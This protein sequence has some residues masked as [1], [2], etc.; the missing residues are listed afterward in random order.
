MLAIGVIDVGITYVKSEIRNF[1]KVL[2]NRIRR[3]REMKQKTDSA[4]VR[5]TITRR[6]T[7]FAFSGEAGHVPQI[8]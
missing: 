1:Y 5:K 8:T 2:E 6:H 3:R 4:F 7:G